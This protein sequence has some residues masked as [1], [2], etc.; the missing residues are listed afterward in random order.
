MQ[1]LSTYA[2]ALPEIAVVLGALLILM[3]GVSRQSGPADYA[4]S[5]LAIVVLLVAA[6]FVVSGPD[7]AVLFDGA[8]IIDGFGRFMKLLVLGGSILVVI[9]S[10]GDLARA[11]L[12]SNEYV[13]LLL[14]SVLGMMLMI[15]AGSLIS[16]YLG[17][18][19]QSLALY[20]VAAIDRGQVRSSEAG[21][22]YFVLGSLSSGMLLYGASLIYGF[23]GSTDFS[24]IA[25]SIHGQSATANIGL[26]I[27][28]VFL[29]VGLAFKISAVP[30]HMWTP[31][32]YEG[33]P[34]PVTAFFAAAPKIAA[35]AL[36]MRV[37]LTAF[38]GIAPQWQQ[39]VVFL[40]IASMLLGAFAA[41]GQTNI[42]R[43]MAYS[44]IGH[45]GYA[46][47]GLA[48]NSEAGTQSVLV[49]LAIY[50]FM[51]V[52]AFACILSMRNKL[53]PVEDIDSLAGLARTDLSM[54]FVLAMI[55]FS[56]AGVPPLAGFFA[57]LYVF[58]AAIQAGLYALA[59]IGVL[60]SVVA[61]YYYLRVVKIMFFDD[62]REA[63]VPVEQ[64]TRIV[65]GLCGLFVLLFVL[66]PAPLVDAALTAARA[67]QAGQ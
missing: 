47:I 29:L 35:M 41:I 4:A 52:G 66:V 18:E 11:K 32:V 38:P 43:L 8:F 39:I 50:L 24:A 36:L 13:V 26:T 46:L 6:K 1:E 45:I 23:T 58:A 56:M 22:K 64:G 7:R 21:L 44:S 48:A 40:S 51:T 2:P 5:G 15:S 61:A 25:A 31:D 55:L 53:G 67:L 14:L 54:A 49:Y 10:I 3:L 57:K 37:L 16:L 30:F 65:M 27:G 60:A 20:V 59:V 42:K 34:T 62:A 63:F 12:L 9:M 17:L 19:L 28:L 33:A